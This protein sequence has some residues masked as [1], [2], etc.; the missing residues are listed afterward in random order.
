M[1]GS[2]TATKNK[3]SN[4]NAGYA[5]AGNVQTSPIK[6]S[7]HIVPQEPRADLDGTGRLVDGYLIETR[8]G[9]L[10]SR[11]GREARVGGVAPTLYREGRA[12]F[13]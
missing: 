8:H 4:A 9:N 13:T 2:L 12:G 3:A 11:R 5:P 10:H 7:I 6:C 1:G